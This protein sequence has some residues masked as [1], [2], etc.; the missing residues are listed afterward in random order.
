ML[1]IIDPIR[2]LKFS[3]GSG[4]EAGA[5]L[6]SLPPN[7]VRSLICAREPTSNRAM[8]P[9]LTALYCQTWPG[10]IHPFNFGDTDAL[11]DQCKELN[12][13]LGNPE[14]A[15]WFV[16]TK[17]AMVV[18]CYNGDIPRVMTAILRSRGLEAD[19]SMKGMPGSTQYLASQRP[20]GLEA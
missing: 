1:D 19:S 7:S 14:L 6:D 2:K 9:A 10:P 18:L 13:M 4:V 3:R 15:Q 17:S 20:C 12:S 16:A 8:S 5:S 11:V